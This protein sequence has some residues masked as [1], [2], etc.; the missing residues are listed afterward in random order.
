MDGQHNSAENELQF[1]E[2]LSIDELE[3][4]LRFS[5]DSADVEMLF[6]AIVEEVVAREEKSPTGRLPSVNTA[7]EEFQ[8]MCRNMPEEKM[9]PSMSA[10]GSEFVPDSED[11]P[12]P[13]TMPAKTQ[14]KCIS[15]RRTIR[16]VSAMVA[17]VILTL[18]LMVGVQAAGVDVFNALARW[19]EDIFHFETQSTELDHNNRL[20]SSIQESL[21]MQESFG[22]YAPKW[23]PAGSIVTDVQAFKDDFGKSVQISLLNGDGKQYFIGVDLYNQSNYID[24]L[25]FEI[26]ADSVEEYISNGKAYFIFTNSETTN[27]V[28]NDGITVY[29]IWGELMIPEIK[30]ML[31]SIGG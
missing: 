3:T 14:S 29:R 26:E 13:S 19:T 4:L 16:T 25:T 18:A 20:Y 9:Q 11:G 8:M 12:V 27:A 22:R 6:D 31:D 24:P 15:F 5:G 10:E 23:Y 28:F 30:S 1:L 2:R 17:A 21:N 7:W